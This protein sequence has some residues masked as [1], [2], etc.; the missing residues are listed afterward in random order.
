MDSNKFYKDNVCII[1]SEGRSL[2]VKQGSGIKFAKVGAVLFS[3]IK[4]SIKSAYNADTTNYSYLKNITLQQLKNYTTLIYKNIPYKMEGGI[5]TPQDY[6]GYNQALNSWYNL[7]PV[8]LSY[9]EDEHNDKYLSY[10]LVLDPAIVNIE[11]IGDLNF[12]G[13]AILGLPYKIMNTEY[14]TPIQKQQN[15][16]ILAFVYFPSDNQKFQILY[17]QPK[18]VAMNYEIH[19]YCDTNE[20]GK[21]TYK[22]YEDLPA[23]NPKR[24]LFGIHMTNDGKHNRG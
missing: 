15:F 19:F 3:D 9:S 6:E 7:I 14:F 13:F 17:N 11:R 21:L 12:D 5:I 16:C 22:T 8:Q 23:K 10:D 4:N 24:F 18:N 20:L 2:F 1:P